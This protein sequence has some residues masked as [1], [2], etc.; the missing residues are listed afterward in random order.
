MSGSGRTHQATCRCSWHVAVRPMR[1]ARAATQI[2][3]TA[4]RG[5]SLDLLQVIYRNTSLA[6]DDKDA[7]SHGGIAI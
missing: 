7:S 2:D 5:M 3:Y 4:W 6:V 1:S